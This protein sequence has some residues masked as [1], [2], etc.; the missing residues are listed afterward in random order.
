MNSNLNGVKISK[1]RGLRGNPIVSAI[2][3]LLVRRGS[4][5]FEKVTDNFYRG[6]CPTIEEFPYLA[7]KGIKKLLDVRTISE[8]EILKRTEA[9]QKSGMVFKNIPWN[10]YNP[11]KYVKAIVKELKDK[12]TT[13]GYCSLGIDRTSNM[14]AIKLILEGMPMYKVMHNMKEHG[15]KGIRRAVFLPMEEAV[16]KFA[17]Q[18]AIK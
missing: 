13:L 1:I 12:A 7:Q 18:Y 11:W 6:A 14:T 4:L 17:K 10:P 3:K 15:F 5:N 2:D 8:E 9:A 16:R